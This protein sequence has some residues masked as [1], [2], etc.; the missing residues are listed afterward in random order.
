MKLVLLILLELLQSLLELSFYS[1]GFANLKEMNMIFFSEKELNRSTID[2]MC[3]SEPLMFPLPRGFIAVEL[4]SMKCYMWSEYAEYLQ[5][6]YKMKDKNLTNTE[7]YVNT[8]KSLKWKSL[9]VFYEN[10]SRK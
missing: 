4:R 1:A 8:V 7:I 9:V 5:N 6:N 10:K 2:V 3:S